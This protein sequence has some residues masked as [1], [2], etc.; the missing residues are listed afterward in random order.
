MN[1]QANKGFQSDLLTLRKVYKFEPNA[2]NLFESDV[3]PET[4]VL[5]DQY[6]DSEEL[7]KGHNIMNIDIEVEVTEGFPMPE[8]ANNK[9]T[10]IATYDSNS[11]TYFAF[12]LDEKNRLTLKSKNRERDGWM[13]KRLPR[14][15]LQII[16]PVPILQ[17]MRNLKSK[18]CSIKHD[19]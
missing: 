19:A 10:S 5:V 2:P 17:T 18:G 11:D 16:R 14:T 12:V 1:E 13:W 4:R 3:P 6:T 9:I 7:S 15:K 8:D